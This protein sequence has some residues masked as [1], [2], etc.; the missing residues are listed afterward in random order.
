LARLE[1]PE[2]TL[3][4][5][6]SSYMDT[7]QEEFQEEDGSSQP[8][9][10]GPNRRWRRW[11]AVFPDRRDVWD[12]LLRRRWMDPKRD[13]EYTYAQHPPRPSPS[14]AAKMREAEQEY[15]DLGVVEREL[16][17][18]EPGST[19]SMFPVA[20]EDGTWRLVVD[21]SLVSLNEVIP[22]FQAPTIDE[23]FRC[24]H[25]DCYFVKS[26]LRK[27][28][29][30]VEAAPAQRR[31]MRFWSVVHQCLARLTAMAMGFSGAPRWAQELMSMIRDYLR[32]VIVM[33]LYSYVDEMLQAAA[34]PVAVYL[35]AILFR[36]LATFLGF[37]FNWPKS[38]RGRPT[39]TTSFCGV[40]MHSSFMTVSPTVRRLE[41]IRK[42]A[43]DLLDRQA[44]SLPVSGLLLSSFLGTV[45]STHRLHQ[46]ASFRTARG[47]KV[48]S[49]FQRVHG[50]R[51]RDLRR[52]YVQPQALGWMLGEL[53]YWAQ[54][55]PTDEWRFSPHRGTWDSVL[56]T[57]SSCYGW[58]SELSPET[59]LG[60][61]ETQGWFTPAQRLYDHDSM[62]FTGTFL[63]QEA[64]RQSPLCR[65][66]SALQPHRQRHD[67]DNVT[68]VTA[69]NKLRCRNLRIAEEASQLVRVNHLAFHDVSAKWINKA[70]MDSTFTADQRGR[71]RSSTW[72]R[73]LD[74]TVFQAI[75]EAFG[76]TGQPLVDLMA[77]SETAQAPRYVSQFPDHRSLWCDALSRPWAARLNS[78][79]H[80]SDLLY[81]FPPETLIERVLQ[82]IEASSCASV[83]LV[84]PAWSRAWIRDFSRMCICQP[85]VF[86][87]GTR[88]LIPPEGGIIAGE[89]VHRNWSWIACVLSCSPD[90]CSAGR[91]RQSQ[92]TAKDGGLL[93]QTAVSTILPGGSGL[94]SLL[95]KAI[96]SSFSRQR[97]SATS[98]PSWARPCPTPSWASSGQPSPPPTMQ[99][100][101]S[102]SQR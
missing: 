60:R 66:G 18:Q 55:N 86:G 45:Q 28:F 72:E 68:V 32:I 61:W 49:Q 34:S 75:L 101:A 77:T 82:H 91:Q 5:E 67:G 16:Q 73:R 59:P 41:T 62:E 11:R 20:K 64:F 96:A 24:M 46:Q 17:P 81:C 98:S 57:D 7:L 99:P 47:A 65:R 26:D 84:V 78:L 22:S 70:T 13:P 53:Q 56:V 39:R 97:Q 76:W 80:R 23:Q 102:T 92:P 74:P 69:L 25:R 10:G 48:R 14:E 1:S 54:P 15:W 50:V 3:N 19:L 44:R 2:F 88:I 6:D 52:N 63:A 9:V 79:L 4:F 37:Q 12:G 93:V 30:Q 71:R 38:D 85:I 95:G 29:F 8:F 35:E 83:L 89:T 21:G 51:R 90:A 42:L 31:L 43:R 87:G 36:V 100:S 27:M 33:N 94:P 40:Q 58:A